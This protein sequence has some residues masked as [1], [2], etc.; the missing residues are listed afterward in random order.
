MKIYKARRGYQCD[1]V[2]CSVA[3]HFIHK[4]ELYI[5]ATQLIRLVSG[6]FRRDKFSYHPECW[7][8]FM[9]RLMEEVK[10]AVKERREKMV[11]PVKGEVGR[12]RKYT[13]PLK[14][15][16]IKANIHYHKR[17]GNKD[18]VK[19]LGKELKELLVNEIRS[20]E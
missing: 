13:D 1:F 12:P 2:G 14:A 20:I 7:E 19:E 16:T 4:G 15:Q 18:R 9:Y 10:K 6:N 11:E 17:V 8:Q 5:R 3:G